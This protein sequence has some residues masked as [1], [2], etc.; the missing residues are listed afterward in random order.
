MYEKRTEEEKIKTKIRLREQGFGV[1]LETINASIEVY[2]NCP[3]KVSS[4]IR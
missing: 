4:S 1:I 3:N 2:L